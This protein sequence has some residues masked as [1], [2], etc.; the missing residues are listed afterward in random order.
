MFEAP[1]CHSEE[2]QLALLT[3]CWPLWFHTKCSMWKPYNC[4][5]RESMKIFEG[6]HETLRVCVEKN[7]VRFRG[8]RRPY[9]CSIILTALFPWLWTRLTRLDTIA[10]LL[11]FDL[12]TSGN[13]RFGSGWFLRT[14]TGSG[15]DGS[16]FDQQNKKWKIT[17]INESTIPEVRTIFDA[18]LL[19]ICWPPNMG[20]RNANH[21]RS[22]FN[23]DLL[24]VDLQNRVPEVRTIFHH[25]ILTNCWPPKS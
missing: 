14:A 6:K 8:Q 4:L 11:R 19:T 25:E 10:C 7:R 13:Q 20:P 3:G 1:P 9:I 21:F 12:I 2:T 22:R 15:S 16:G 17:N 24:T 18:D 5:Q 23:D